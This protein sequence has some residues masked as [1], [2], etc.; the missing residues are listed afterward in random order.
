M[1]VLAIAAAAAGTVPVGPGVWRPLF[2]PSPE[3]TEIAVEAFRLDETPVTN[4][5]FLAFVLENPDWR[6][7]RIARIRADTGY[8]SRW[9]GPDVPGAEAPARAPVTD[10][11]WFAARAFCS[12][13][14]GRLPTEAEWELAAA[15]SE[16]E[17]DAARDPAFLARVL[18][19]YGEPAPPVLPEVGGPANAWGVRDL[20]GLVWEWVDDFNSSIVSAGPRGEAGEA[21]FCGA[22]SAS[23]ESS[24]SYAGFMRLAFRSSL[25]AS[26]TTRQL[27]FRCAE[28]S[29]PG[30]G[31][32]SAE[33]S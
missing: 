19:W 33:G 22:G 16:T 30:P 5:A 1:V 2:P 9:A 7:D 4:E 8:L 28:R 11:S 26:Y 13:R 23:A 20:H 21:L 15:A 3:E 29:S 17:R 24:T 12:A 25:Q 31:P 10:V 6:R 32:G 14:G 18:K 27:G